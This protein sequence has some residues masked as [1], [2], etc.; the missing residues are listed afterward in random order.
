MDVRK[1]QTSD[2]Q[3]SLELLLSNGVTERVASGFA[4]TLSYGRI[5]ES[6]EYVNSRSN[7][8]DPAAMIVECLKYAWKI[9]AGAKPIG[10][11]SA[12]GPRCAHCNGEGLVQAWIR[13]SRTEAP[14]GKASCGACKGRGWKPT[15]GQASGGEPRHAG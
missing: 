15:D 8:R 5:R 14:D 2:W 9:P 10:T 3:S 7:V 13:V 11:P 1:A 6:V 4:R 12:R